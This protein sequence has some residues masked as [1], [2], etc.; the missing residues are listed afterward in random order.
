MRICM[1]IYAHLYCCFQA[2][3]E[4]IE[5]WLR[6]YEA[7]QQAHRAGHARLWVGVG[8]LYTR[9]MRNALLLLIQ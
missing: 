4:T 2:K 9:M 3:A 5:G 6:E 8:M 1:F 7:L